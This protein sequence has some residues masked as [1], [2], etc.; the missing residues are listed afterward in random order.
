MSY[1]E[2]LKVG[3]EADHITSPACCKSRDERR[4]AVYAIEDNIKQSS[5]ID[6]DSLVDEVIKAVS[7]DSMLQ[8]AFLENHWILKAHR[9]P[10]PVSFIPIL[11]P[12]A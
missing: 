4:C 12:N 9:E 2:A 7:E 11:T 5:I 6:A 10:R 1:N 8:I 3:I